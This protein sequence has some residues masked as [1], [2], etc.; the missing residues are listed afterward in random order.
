MQK[1]L[2]LLENLLIFQ[3][4]R[5]ERLAALVV[6]C[7]R[8]RIGHRKEAERGSRSCAGQM[9]DAAIG[10]DVHRRVGHD[11]CHFSNILAV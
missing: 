11:G 5:D 4:S 2:Q 1:F 10:S 9:H 3:T 6:G 7:V 8:Q